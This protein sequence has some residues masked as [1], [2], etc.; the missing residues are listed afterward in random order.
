[1]CRRFAIVGLAALISGDLASAADLAPI[2]KAPIPSPSL[3]D[4]SGLYVGANAG[5]GWEKY[6]SEFAGTANSTSASGGL[7]GA[8][9]GYN[10]QIDRSVFG[11]E[12]DFDW[13]DLKGNDFCPAG[14]CAVK[15]NSLGTVRG[16]IGYAG[17][18]FLSY[19][20]GGFAFGNIE[21][22]APLLG[23]TH[24]F[25]SGWTAGVGVEY[26]LTNAWSIK[27]EYLYVD[28]GK[29]DCGISCGGATSIESTSQ[30][31][32]LGLNYKFG[33]EE[34]PIVLAGPGIK[35]PPRRTLLANPLPKTRHSSAVLVADE[36]AAW[37]SKRSDPWS[38]VR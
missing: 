11:I 32:R 38:G 36:T 37:N 31:V 4:W 29:L 10:F 12:G 22:R 28:L 33:A 8:T 27:A 24:G 16:R 21:V 35:P 1:M 19:V 25:Q 23:A 20:T 18:R 3:T 7:V 9:I 26:A 30:V 14:T 13:L 34:K 2:F 5:G 17:E 6:T 15:N